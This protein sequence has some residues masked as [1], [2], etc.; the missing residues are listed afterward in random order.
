M[1]RKPCLPAVSRL[2]MPEL[3]RELNVMLQA[4]AFSHSMAPGETATGMRSLWHPQCATSTVQSL[5]RTAFLSSCSGFS[6]TP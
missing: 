1:S 6:S 2:M 5:C 3:Q 4:S